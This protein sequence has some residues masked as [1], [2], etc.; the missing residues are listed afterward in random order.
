MTVPSESRSSPR[1]EWRS[2]DEGSGWRGVC[3]SNGCC[4]FLLESFC[5]RFGV[6][7]VEVSGGVGEEKMGKGDLEL[8][9]NSNMSGCI[10]KKMWVLSRV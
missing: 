3:S 4:W 10:T 9:V 1:R 8:W 6:E 5:W 2:G 7:L